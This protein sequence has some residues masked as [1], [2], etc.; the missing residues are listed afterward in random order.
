MELIFQNSKYNYHYYLNTIMKEIMELKQT[1]KSKLT[2]FSLEVRVNFRSLF[3]LS[4]VNIPTILTC[5]IFKRK[6]NLISCFKRIGVLIFFNEFM[7]KIVHW[8]RF[9][10][11]LVEKLLW[12]NNYPEQYQTIVTH[13]W[14]DHTK[15]LRVHL[16]FVAFLPVI[17]T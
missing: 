12:L 9:S 15:F 16:L 10:F 8:V 4:N 14:W 17:V 13:I 3:L 6:W 7:K 11:N 2:F 1:N 5:S